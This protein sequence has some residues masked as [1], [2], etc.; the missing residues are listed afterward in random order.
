MMESNNAT[1]QVK[2][3][4]DF[5][6]ALT[7]PYKVLKQLIPL[8]EYRTEIAKNCHWCEQADA[9]LPF[10]THLENLEFIN[11]QIKEVLGL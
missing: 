4:E 3:R 7:D 8:L 6:K 11:K 2:L 10:K 5:M 1:S 9:E